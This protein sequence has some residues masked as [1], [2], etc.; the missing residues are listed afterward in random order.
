MC[1]SFICFLQVNVDVN[2]DSK[3]QT[4]Q[5][6]AFPISNNAIEMI[7]RLRDGII[8]YVQLV[9]IYS[10]TFATEFYLTYFICFFH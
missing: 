7:G 6:L 3:S 8:S 2:V 1:L 10:P 9:S 5:G 4:M